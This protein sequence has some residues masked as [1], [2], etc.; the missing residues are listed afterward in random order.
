ME[1]ASG[2]KGLREKPTT[3][4]PT[5]ASASAFTAFTAFTT[6][7]TAAVSA[8]TTAASRGYCERSIE[9]ELLFQLFRFFSV[10][11]LLA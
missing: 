11:P 9:N 1:G 7:T 4:P 5:C 6:F 2:R 10:F 3:G 8:T